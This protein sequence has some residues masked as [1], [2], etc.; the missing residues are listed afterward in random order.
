MTYLFLQKKIEKELND[1]GVDSPHFSS[2]ILITHFLDIPQYVLFMN[3]EI[4]EKSEKLENLYGALL[5]VKNGYPIDYVLG[6]KYFFNLKIS[7]DNNTL[8]PRPE[9]EGLVDLVIK[10]NKNYSKNFADVGTGSGAIALK[11]A[12][13]YPGSK[14]YATDIYKKTLDKAIENSKILKIK[15]I[16][17]LLGENYK[18][19]KNYISK[20]NIIVSNPPYIKTSLINNLEPKVR[21][22]EPIYALDGGE[23]GTDIIKEL[24]LNLPEK[25]KLY[26]EIADYNIPSII[27]CCKAKMFS[28]RFEK[29][30]F[31]KLRY[32]VI[33]E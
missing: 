10:E 19:L 28:W 13:T 30:I 17:F 2:K 15:N 9:T 8:I 14:V 25:T 22:Y 29:D 33:N 12:D 7:I 18:P 21:N 27:K 16:F 6:Y 26:L 4:S 24:V 3:S 23:N 1:S 32:A 20:I 11:L 31:N 5:K